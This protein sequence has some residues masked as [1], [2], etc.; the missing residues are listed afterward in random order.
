MWTI[1]QDVESIGE[2]MPVSRIQPRSIEPVVVSLTLEL[3]RSLAV[4]RR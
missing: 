2:V 1:M 3:S 4:R